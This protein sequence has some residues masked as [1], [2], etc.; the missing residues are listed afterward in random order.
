MHRYNVISTGALGTHIS[1]MPP[2][3][4]SINIMFI[5]LMLDM[6]LSSDE[7]LNQLSPHIRRPLRLRRPFSGSTDTE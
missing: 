7:H 2:T 5:D 3:Q 1:Y 4:Q 6:L